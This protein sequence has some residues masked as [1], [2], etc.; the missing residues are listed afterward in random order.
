MTKVCPVKTITFSSSNVWMWESDH[1]E[2][3]ALKDSCFPI[4]VLEKT[5]QSPLDCKEIKSVYPKGN[6]P[7]I[8]IGRTDADAEA[9]ILWPPDVRNWLIGK[10]PDAG[11]DWKQKEKRVAEDEMVR[12]HHRLNGQESEQTL[13]DSGGQRILPCL[14]SIASMESQRVG[15]DLVTEQQHNSHVR[16]IYIFLALKLRSRDT[17]NIIRV[18]SL[19]K[20]RWVPKKLWELRDWGPELTDIYSVLFMYVW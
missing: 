11:K 1:K 8:F 14:H 2:G 9:P 15:H 17:H 20:L 18:S 6:Q 16:K 7:W 5:L 4:V 19:P 12:Q 3:L 13:G 10:D